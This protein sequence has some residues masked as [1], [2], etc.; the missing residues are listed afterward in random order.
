VYAPEKQKG[1]RMYIDWDWK[2]TWLVLAIFVIS[3]GF[4]MSVAAVGMATYGYLG[5]KMGVAVVAGLLT[6][7]TPFVFSSEKFFWMV[8]ATV[9][10]AC[11]ISVFAWWSLVILFALIVAGILA[12]VAN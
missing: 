5:G 11:A 4:G 6:L 1:V 7:F 2:R 12:I 8:W 3:V 9:V 10:T